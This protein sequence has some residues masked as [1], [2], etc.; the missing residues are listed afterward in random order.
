MSKHLICELLSN[1]DHDIVAVWSA[2]HSC[3]RRWTQTGPLVGYITSSLSL[4]FPSF[5]LVL[6]LN[7]HLVCDSKFPITVPFLVLVQSWHFVTRMLI[8]FQVYAYYCVWP[9]SFSTTVRFFPRYVDTLIS[10]GSLCS[11]KMKQYIFQ[12][13]C[14]MQDKCT[15]F[16]KCDS[17][18]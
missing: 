4:Q 9:Y 10:N 12:Q 18:V 14:I 3:C 2:Q 5:I 1:L 6:I 11:S 7:V 16:W 8:S 15:K 13:L 17:K